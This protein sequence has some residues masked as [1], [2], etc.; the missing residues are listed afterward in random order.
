M[1][2]R[3]N[4]PYLATKA[5]LTREPGSKY[6]LRSQHLVDK[7]TG[8]IAVH[9]GGGTLKGMKESILDA[10]RNPSGFTQ[11]SLEGSLDSI[12]MIDF[13]PEEAKEVM[14]LLETNFSGGPLEAEAQ[15]ALQTLKDK[16]PK[17]AASKFKPA[18]TMA[19]FD[20]LPSPKGSG[21]EDIATRGSING[22]DGTR[23]RGVYLTEETFG[24]LEEKDLNGLMLML[25]RMK[26]NGFDMWLFGIA[27]G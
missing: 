27:A 16:Y 4:N 20:A 6:L 10:L 2:S 19:H 23:E 3:I 8:K 18:R 25:P 14:G 1:P 7:R 13:T 9:M 11:E 5:H 26:Q 22:T 12:D 21:G 24:I 15:Q 17:L